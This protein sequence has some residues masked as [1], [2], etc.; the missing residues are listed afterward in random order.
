MVTGRKERRK[1][2]VRMERKVELPKDG[3]E[4]GSESAASSVDDIA[5]EWPWRPRVKR[6]N[7]I[8]VVS[9]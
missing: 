2:K 9:K 1:K 6:E 4:G 8:N 5:G 3:A 7:F